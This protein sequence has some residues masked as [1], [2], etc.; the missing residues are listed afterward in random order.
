METLEL[1]KTNILKKFTQLNLI[2]T[3][4]GYTDIESKDIIKKINKE[5]PHIIWVGMGTPKQ[6]IW[7]N[8][9][10]AKL[11]C[12]VIQAVGD[13]FSLFANTKVRGPKFFQH[14]GLEW[15]F[16]LLSEPKRFWRRYVLGIP[17]FLFFVLKEKLSYYK[18]KI[19][20]YF[21]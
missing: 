8:E 5:K 12:N 21:L 9:N 19:I 13:I 6:E 14:L 4:N 11:N 1:A 10:K 18:K 15:L 2:G 17:K 7:I 20:S 16:R 3:L